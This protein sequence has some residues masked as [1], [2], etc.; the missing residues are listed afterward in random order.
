MREFSNYVRFK[1]NDYNSVVC[2][3]VDLSKAFDTVDHGLLLES[4]WMSGIRG[5]LHEWFKHYLS[6][7]SF[8]VV[9]SSDV[10]DLVP[11]SCGEPQG[12]ILCPLVF[13]IR[14]RCGHSFTKWSVLHL[15]GRFGRCYCLG[16]RCI[17]LSAFKTNNLQVWTHDK[18]LIINHQETKV[19]HIRSPHLKTNYTPCIIHDH[20]CLHVMGLSGG[21]CLCRATLEIVDTFCFT[22]LYTDCLFC[23]LRQST[24]AWS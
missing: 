3:F 11:L 8:R 23:G 17:R 20:N 12:S 5:D 16:W 13:T 14:Q 9:F 15:R 22:A 4:L 2:H 1:L 18:K 19:M 7:R 24:F 21:V 10:V 6:E